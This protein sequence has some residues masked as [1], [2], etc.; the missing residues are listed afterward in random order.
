[1]Y[2]AWFR[3]NCEEEVAKIFRTEEQQA[4]TSEMP[5]Y[6]AVKTGD[7]FAHADNWYPALRELFTTAFILYLKWTGSIKS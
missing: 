6:G 3:S 2:H 7:I 4:I 5:N 1:M